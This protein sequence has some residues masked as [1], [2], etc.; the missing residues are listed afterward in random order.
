MYLNLK[1]KTKKKSMRN[2]LMH[3]YMNI[4]SVIACIEAEK[5]SIV[6]NK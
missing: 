3:K 5:A 1:K 4:I 6:I 2:K